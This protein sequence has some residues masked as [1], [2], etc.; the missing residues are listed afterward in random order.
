MRA[1]SHKRPLFVAGAVLLL[2]AVLLDP[3]R[4]SQGLLRGSWFFSLPRLGEL[5]LA[6]ALLGVC[7]AVLPW[8]LARLRPAPVVAPE[9][10]R[11]SRPIDWIFALA[12]AANATAVL[13]RDDPISK[14]AKF[15]LGESLDIAARGGPLALVGRCF[16]GSWAEDNRHPFYLAAIAPFARE[17]LRF[18]DAAR[19]V[20]LAGAL[21]TLLLCLR[22]CRRRGGEP[23]AALG[24]VLL[25]SNAAFV[26]Q[27]ASVACESWWTAFAVL[28]VD[29]ATRNDAIGAARRWGVVGASLGMAFLSKG[30]GTLLALAIV[31]WILWSERSRAWR[32]LLLCAFAFTLVALPLLVRNQLRFGNPLYN[33]NSSRVFWLDGWKEF[34]DPQA[35]AQAGPWHYLASHSLA[36]IVSRLGSGLLKQA[37]HALEALAPFSPHPAFGVPGFLLLG[38]CVAGSG[39]RRLRSCLCM[40]AAFWLGSFAWYAQASSGYQYLAVL[41]PLV[42]PALAELVSRLDTRGANAMRTASVA[43]ALLL[44][45]VSLFRGAFDFRPARVVSP[46]WNQE[47]HAYLRESTAKEPDA[48]YL[49]G[50][51]R[52]LG[53]DWDRSLLATRHARPKNARAGQQLLGASRG[54]R[55]RFLV[56]EAHGGPR[57]FGDDWVSCGPEGTLVPGAAAPGWSHVAGF[58]AHAPRVLVFERH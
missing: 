30:T 55:V 34:S 54:D 32:A 12:L 33:V 52:E 18:V 38:L 50:P 2:A 56:V 20:S 22:A 1:M 45:C 58:P 42:L 31:A 15:Y 16:D 57:R 51:S 10:R 53:F 23:A 21:L 19:G 24:G 14:D 13:V 48:I 49:L 3:Q 4:L 6:L 11:L 9:G 39:D 44:A 41:V 46:A 47:L 26:E 36:E 29:Q 43:A 5:R 40:I 27:A 25:V 7:L 28:A 17:S 8:L 35:M 37:V